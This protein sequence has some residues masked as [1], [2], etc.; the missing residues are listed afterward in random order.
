MSLMKPNE[1]YIT[2]TNNE[3][4]IYSFLD[5][6]IYPQREN[7]LKWSKITNQTPNL[8]IGYPG[9]HLASLITG[10]KGTG[11]G[12]RGDDLEDLSEVKSCSRVD[13]SDK[14][15][16]CGENVLRSQSKC[17][18]CGSECI[19]RNNDSKWLIGIRNDEELRM[20]LEKIPRTIFIISDY[21]E[22]EKNNY[23]KI[24]FTAYEIWNQSDRA[25]NFREVLINYYENIY[26]KKKKMDS[27]GSIAPLN[28]WPY[29][30]QFYMCNPIKVFHATIDYSVPREKAIIIDHYIKPTDDR[31]LL[32]SEKMPCSLLNKEERNLIFSNKQPVLEIG[33]QERE[34]LSLRKTKGVCV[35]ENKYKRLK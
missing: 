7:M 18:H 25:R 24:Q 20:Y 30:F 10:V 26:K 23:N 4:L 3:E 19:K 16:N 33:E 14:C 31:S 2:I 17:P 28:F 8:K 13:Q 9:Q 29:N 5:E 34:Y 1:K 32:E 21:P 22:F 6:V 12:A 35:H 27:E 15:K 11:T